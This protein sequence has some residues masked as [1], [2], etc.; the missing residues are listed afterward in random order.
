MSPASH[1]TFRLELS[2]KYAYH[3][4]GSSWVMK[5]TSP[6]S[7]LFL[8]LA[9][10]EGALSKYQVK[11]CFENQKEKK[12]HR[13]NNIKGGQLFNRTSEALIIEKKANNIALSI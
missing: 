9:K 4:G 10:I 2:Y 5:K 13:S 6:L 12:T 1:L 3:D 8:S 7:L 11:E